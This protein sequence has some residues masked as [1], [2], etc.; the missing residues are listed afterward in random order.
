MCSVVWKTAFS[1]LP[2]RVIHGVKCYFFTGE[3]T[4]VGKPQRHSRRSNFMKRCMGVSYCCKLS[5]VATVRFFSHTAVAEAACFKRTSALPKCAPNHFKAP[6]LKSGSYTAFCASHIVVG[7]NRKN[8][9]HQDSN[10]SMRPRCRACSN[11]N[12]F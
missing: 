10:L 2:N 11:C 9:D 8:D 7:S 1:S 5:Q 6:V 4:L 3:H 12:G